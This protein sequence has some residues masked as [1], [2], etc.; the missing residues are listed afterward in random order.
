MAGLTPRPGLQ[1]LL[2]EAVRA[3][4]TPAASLVA[5]G[6]GGRTLEL[7]AGDGA[8]ELRYDLAS[9]TKVLYTAAAAKLLV[10]DSRLQWQ[11]V[12]ELLLHESGLPWWRPFHEEIEAAPGL[13]RP[14]QAR[15]QVRARVRALALEQPAGERAVYSDPGFIRLEEQLERRHAGALEALVRQRLWAP[16]GLDSLTFVD[17]TT[18]GAPAAARAAAPYAPTELC[19]WRGR[20]LHAEVHDDNAWAMGGVAGHAGLFGTAADVHGFGAGLLACL[21]AES[22]LLPAQVVETAWTTRGRAPGST[23]VL[24]WDTPTPG[25]S[26]AGSRISAAGVGH[27]GFTGTSLWIDPQAEVVV[28]LLTNRVYSGRDDDRIRRLRPAVHDAVFD[29]LRP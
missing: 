1:E 8:S 2:D 28:A 21:R 10:A 7:H 15:E 29:L 24:G 6:P 12:A 25:A 19:P 14:A 5:S 22:D 23:R 18:A 9:L 13:P 3:G 11:D 4:V 16:L 27:L 17:L 20:R 26:S